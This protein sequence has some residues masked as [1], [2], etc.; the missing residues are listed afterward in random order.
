MINPE[1]HEKDIGRRVLCNKI[2]EKDGARKKI[3]LYKGEI[4]AISE[5]TPYIDEEGKISVIPEG[6]K[7]TEI[8]TKEQLDWEPM[9]MVL[10]EFIDTEQAII[11]NVT[12][13]EKPYLRITSAKFECPS[14]GTIISVLQSDKKYRQPSRCSCGRRGGFKEISKEVEDAQDIIIMQKNTLFEFK[15]YVE[16]KKLID[17]LR[18][19]SVKNFLNITGFVRAEYPKKLTRG[20]YLIEVTDIEEKFEVKPAFL[21]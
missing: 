3:L 16:G 7:Q 5:E 15:A 14:C 2:K 9:D 4:S 12:T 19:T 10:K 21:K 11:C 13:V 6:K 8:Y 18:N 17:Y 20:D 1:D